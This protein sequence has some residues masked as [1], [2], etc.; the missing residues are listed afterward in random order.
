[1][2]EQIGPYNIK[3]TIHHLGPISWTPTTVD[4]DGVRRGAMDQGKPTALPPELTS[5]QKGRLAAEILAF[6]AHDY[7]L[8]E[9][10][11]RYGGAVTEYEL[12]TSPHWQEK[13]HKILVVVPRMGQPV[14]SLND[15]V[16]KAQV[17]TGSGYA[18]LV[19]R[20]TQ[21]RV[22]VDWLPLFPD[23]V[24][25][26][27]RAVVEKLAAA[28]IVGDE[29]AAAET[30]RLWFPDTWE[31]SPGSIRNELH[32][33]L[34]VLL[35]HLQEAAAQQ[36]DNESH[37]LDVIPREFPGAVRSLRADYDLDSIKDETAELPDGA[38]RRFLEALTDFDG[39]FSSASLSPQELRVMR[40]EIALGVRGERWSVADK[41]KFHGFTTGAYKSAHHEAKRKLRLATQGSPNPN[42]VLLNTA[43]GK[44][45]RRG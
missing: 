43:F 8:P 36:P 28:I 4:S 2:T 44:R 6:L 34:Y 17:S 19:R 29:T 24:Q 39:R 45:V 1:M 10:E 9:L 13:I 12:L 22:T 41:A 26:R 18:L 25:Q 32:K 3:A 38:R 21:W 40:F 31:N 14:V 16:D 33:E 7:I 27:V 23:S 35:F 20:G 5:P 11:R 15:E 30:A 37:P 42:Q